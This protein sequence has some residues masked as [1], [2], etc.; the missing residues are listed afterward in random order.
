MFHNIWDNSIPLT[1]SIELICSRWL[2]LVKTTNQKTIWWWLYWTH[3]HT[4][5]ST[6]VTGWPRITMPQLVVAPAK[7]ASH[8]VPHPSHV[9]SQA[10]SSWIG[11]MIIPF[12][13]PNNN[14]HNPMGF[15][16]YLITYCTPNAPC[17]VYLP[18]FGRFV[19]VN[20]H[21]YSIH[22]AYGYTV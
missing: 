4:L 19:G 17:M 1:N 5:L 3:T 22:G 8:I 16:L 15:G 14:H 7:L 10:P 2:K 20:V 11:R 9:E 6:S 13:Y 21:N 18:T 12:F